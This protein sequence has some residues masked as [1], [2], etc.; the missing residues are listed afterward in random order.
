MTAPSSIPAP[1]PDELAAAAKQLNF[2]LD[3]AELGVFGALMQ[4]LVADCNLVECLE[5]PTLAVAYPRGQPHQPDATANPWNAWAWQCEIK[6]SASGKLA[7]KR[8]VIKDNIAVA[9][10]PLL[11]GSKVYEGFVPDEDAT[12]VTRVLDAGGTIL[13]KGTC[14]NFCFSGGSHTSA[15]GP[16]RNPHNPDYMTGGSSSGCAALIVAGECDMGIGS[17]QGG[18]V[19]MPASFSGCVGIKPSYGLVPYTGAGPIDQTVDHLG[20]MAASSADCALLLEVIAGGDEGR[21]PRQSAGLEPKPYTE[22]IDGGVRGLRIGLVRESF[23]TPGA[24]ADVDAMVAAAARRLADAGAVV[25]EVSVPMHAQ[26]AGIMIVSILDGTLSTFGELGPFGTNARGHAMLGAIRFYQEAR[27][28]RAND[29]PVTVKTV[30]LCAQV[31]RNRYGPYYSAKAQNL[32]RSLRAAYDAALVHYDLLAMPTTPMK[33]HRIPPPDAP[34]EVVMGSALDMVGNT[35]P[36][37]VTGHPSISVPC[38]MSEGLP[39]GLMLTGRYGEDD[40]VLRAGHAF[41]RL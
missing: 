14:E 15:T 23:G 3:T 21:D 30:M 33:A 31:M 32:V 28:T 25:E 7:G 27:R 5:S 6:G 40:V 2:D 17:D 29:M 18:S 20:P 35:A 22:L 9:G 16:V 24:Q 13:G 8:I 12:V 34:A 26:G 37:D 38:G 39:V 10:I 4:G 1:R 19:R 41:E 36:F 11:N